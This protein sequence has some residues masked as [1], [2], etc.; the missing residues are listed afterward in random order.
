MLLTL[1]GTPF[2]YYGDELGAARRAVGP[3]DRARPGRAAHRRPGATTATC[4][5]TPMPWSDEPGGG[6]TTP[7]ATPW[8]PFGD[9]AAHNVAAQRADPGSTLH[10]VRDLIALRR[11]ER[12]LT[13]GRLRV[14]ARARPARGRGA[15]GDGFVVALNLSDAPV[16][17]RRRRRADR[18][19]HRPRARRRGGRRRGRARAVGGRAWSPA[20]ER[21]RRSRRCSRRRAGRTPRCR[22]RSPATRAASTRCSAATR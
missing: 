22:R 5:R 14:A 2:L 11:G 1:R 9:L 12:D 16:D 8:L 4:C 21:R 6:F 19:R 10:L 13:H 18:D 7:D 17:G 20:D 15:R 3:A